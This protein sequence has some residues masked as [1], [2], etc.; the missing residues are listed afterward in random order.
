M[1]PVAP[2]GLWHLWHLKPAACFGET[3]R[4]A[5]LSSLSCT[6]SHCA[7]CQSAQV[8]VQVPDKEKYT[9][10]RH[11]ERDISPVKFRPKVNV[12]DS[13]ATVGDFGHA[14]AMPVQFVIEYCYCDGPAALNRVVCMLAPLRSCPAA[15]T[16]LL[17]RL[18]F[19]TIGRKPRIQSWLSAGVAAATAAASQDDGSS[20]AWA[21][22]Q[23][24]PS[25]NGARG[26]R[27]SSAVSA[28]AGDQAVG[29]VSLSLCRHVPRCQHVVTRCAVV[30]P[31]CRPH[32]CN[33]SRQGHTVSAQRSWLER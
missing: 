2:E 33:P 4:Q 7:C 28:S 30:P 11:R 22:A 10:L 18:L 21:A 8:R 6:C 24:Q 5:R 1:A 3:R 15:A 23:R 27:A 12:V 13:A 26:G 29:L 9:S 32:P 16:A 19:S 20:G 17:P 25:S 31:S 14:N